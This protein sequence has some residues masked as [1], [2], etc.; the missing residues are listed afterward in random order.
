MLP[1]F[2][3]GSKN[4]LAARD[5]DR[6]DRRRRPL[7][8]AGEV[9]ARRAARRRLATVPVTFSVGGEAVPADRPAARR[10]RRLG[11]RRRQRASRTAAG[12]GS[13]AAT[14][15]CR[16]S[17][18]RRTSRRRRAPTTPALDYEL[19]L[20]TQRRRRTRPRRTAR[21]ARPPHHDRRR[22][23]RA[24]RSIVQSPRDEIIGALASF[25]R[26]PVALPVTVAPPRVTIASLTAA[27]RRASI[28]RLRARAR[29]R[30]RHDVCASRA[31][32]SRR[33]STS[34]PCASR[35]RRRTPISL[36]SRRQVDQAAEGR[37]LRRREQ[38]DHASSLPSPASSSTF[39]ARRASVLAAASRATNRV[40]TRLPLAVAQP[41]RST[42]AAQAMGI[43][44]VGR[45]VRDVLRRRSE[46]H[47]QRAARGAPRR[48]QADRPRRR[49]SRSTAR[50]ASGAPPRGSSR[51]P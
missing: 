22:L 13:S 38:Q 9:A 2:F 49:R 6:R 46:P 23:V 27:Q 5:A 42:A 40:V 15:V 50:Q 32:A 43:T 34:T 10:R 36:G 28:D 20:I 25:S 24:Q 8:R 31:G 45:H 47:P 29:D 11:C 44:G 19:Q 7:G 12:S 41:K 33:S 16:S 18:S 21:A 3:A 1:L 30:R 39:R 4:R 35:G 17:S 37:R 26:A 48:Q 51:R 14:A